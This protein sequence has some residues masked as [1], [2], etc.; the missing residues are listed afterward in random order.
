MPPDILRSIFSHCV[1]HY[2]IERSMQVS[3]A[4]LLLTQICRHWRDL[5]I[6]TPTLWSTIF[7]RI[8]VPPRGRYH[9]SHLPWDAQEGD[10]DIEAEGA[11]DALSASLEDVWRRKTES[12]VSLTNIWLSRAEGCP[13]SIFFRDVDSDSHLPSSPLSDTDSFTQKPVDRLLS[14]ICARSSQW[15][16]LDLRVPESGASEGTFLSQPPSQTPHL[17]TIRVQWSPTRPDRVPLSDHSES[18]P[19]SQDHD[20]DTVKTAQRPSFHIFEA[21]RLHHLSIDNFNGHFKDLSVAWGN[22]TELSY[23]GRPARYY[24]AHSPP[25]DRITQFPPSA[26]LALLQECPNLLKCELHLSEFTF[27]SDATDQTTLSNRVHLPHLARFV[28]FE[29]KQSP[30]FG[31]FKSLDLPLL[32]SI[33][34]SSTISPFSPGSLSPAPLHLSI[35]PLLATSGHQ[36]QY[37]EFGAIITSVAQLVDTLE[38][39]LGVKELTIDMSSVIFSIPTSSMDGTAWSVPQRPFYRDEL[40]RRLTPSSPCSSLSSSSFSEEVLC[41]NLV[42]LKLTLAEPS[43][44]TTKALKNLVTQRG[45]IESRIAEDE[46]PNRTSMHAVPP[47]LEQVSVRFSA[48][49]HVGATPPLPK[50]WEEDRLNSGFGRPIIKVERRKVALHGQSHAYSA[51]GIRRPFEG[52]W[53]FESSRYEWDECDVSATTV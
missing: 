52:Y 45:I 42:I 23:T 22:L 8:P 10:I 53:D 35:Y 9:P 6:K 30:S 2:T 1:P 25:P 43:D 34:W 20:L 39:A 24:G 33:S 12:L 28:I 47:P 3:S 13:L 11:S 31:F 7:L 40:L 5:A 41:P 17:R 29:H 51:E 48:P 37:L 21:T 18:T 19:P 14:L 36:I 44:I 26:A 49:Y 27:N 4:P 15:A 32:S 38:L 16:Q 50:R 46:T